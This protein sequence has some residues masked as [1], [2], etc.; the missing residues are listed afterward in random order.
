MSESNSTTTDSSSTPPGT[1]GGGK[2]RFEIGLV[3]AGTVS[4]GAYTAGVL[5]LFL[6]ALDEREAARRAAAANPSDPLHAAAIANPPLDPFHEVVI[7]V[8]SGTSGGGMNAALLFAHADR[9]VPPARTAAQASAG[10][11]PF[12]E[13]WVKLIDLRRLLT[14]SD[15]ASPAPHRS[16]S[17]LNG[18]VLDDIATKVF[19]P[20][21]PPLT[22]GRPGIASD[23]HL[24]LTVTNQEGINY[25]VGFAPGSPVPAAGLEMSLHADYLHFVR[26]D[27]AAQPQP[28]ADSH[29]TSDACAAY[30]VAFATTGPVPASNQKL[31]VQAGLATGAFPVGLPARRIERQRHDYERWPLAPVVS[32][33]AVPPPYGRLHP[34]LV[35]T[36]SSPP[37]AP[38][39]QAIPPRWDQ[40]ASSVPASPP[41]P[42][43]TFWAVDGGVHNNEPLELVRRH[44]AGSAPRNPR[45]PLEADSFTVLIDP[46][47]EAEPVSN[48]SQ[49]P[50]LLTTFGKVFGGLKATSRFKPEDLL[51]AYDDNNY[52]RFLLTAS[53]PATPAHV[54][55]THLYGESALGSGTLGAFSGFIDV[56]F[57]EHDYLLGRWNA[58]KFLKDHFALEVIPGQPV[59][60]RFGAGVVVDLAQTPY[61]FITELNAPNGPVCYYMPI[62]PL[63]GTAKAGMDFGQGKNGQQPPEWP[64]LLPGDVKALRTA[65]NQRLK[66]VLASWDREAKGFWPNFL[67][68]FA[69]FVR[70]F[71]QYWILNYIEKT[72]SEKLRAHRLQ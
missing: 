55:R 48:A 68:K 10:V 44:L 21:E 26:A 47:V 41:T 72:L 35:A 6:E 70:F 4:A 30:S 8:V 28:P 2:P 65:I 24:Y 3:L 66:A 17:V 1:A 59:N 16:A 71:G 69:R 29:P 62:L 14:V 43:H 32:L 18:A 58:Q 64:V 42:L 11:N 25:R 27:P 34:F 49:P 36:P 54:S 37:G 13:A 20:T 23:L 15:L 50:D 40:P 56:R 60:P 53:R 39:V 51:L 63:F 33:P 52:S 61:G 67:A 45:G 38:I 7:P 31:L 5:D 12:A 22:A 57:R 19:T 9:P 46:L